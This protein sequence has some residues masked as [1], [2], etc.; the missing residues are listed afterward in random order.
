MAGSSGTLGSGVTTPLSLNAA[1]MPQSGCATPPTQWITLAHVTPRA[2][3]VVF[4]AASGHRFPDG[5]VVPDRGLLGSD[6]SHRI[7]GAGGVQPLAWGRDA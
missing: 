5:D 4:L 7:G 3:N 2:V 6:E 1:K